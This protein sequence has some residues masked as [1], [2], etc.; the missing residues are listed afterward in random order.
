[1]PVQGK[2]FPLFV[3][4]LVPL[5]LPSTTKLRRLCFY[6]CVSVHGGGWY[7]S[8]PCRWYPSMPCSRSLGGGGCAIPACIAGGTPACLATSLQGGVC[9]WGVCSWGD[10][11]PG[12]LVSQHALRQ[13]PP[14]ERRLLLRRVGIPLKCILVLDWKRVKRFIFNRRYVWEMRIHQQPTGLQGVR[15]AGG[16]EPGT[17]KVWF[18]TIHSHQSKL[19][20]FVSLSKCQ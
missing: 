7:P 20:K 2:H 6:R 19:H 13:T 11:L 3:F 12:G 15:H 5:L 10:L 16:I 9:S 8:M 18:F 14:R 4:I 1:M 17:T